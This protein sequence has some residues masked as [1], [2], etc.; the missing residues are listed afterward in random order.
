MLKIL[1][2]I[3]SINP[4]EGGTNLAV[5]EIVKALRHFGVDAEIATT[6]DNGSSN[7]DVPLQELIEYNDVPV[8]FFSR[9]LSNNFKFINEFK[10]SLEFTG[11][12]E[13]NIQNYHTIH[14]HSF[15]SYLCTRG[16]MIARKKKINYVITPHGQLDNWVINQKRWKKEIY[17]LLWERGNLNNATA[18]HCTTANEANDV[19]KFGIPVPIFTIPL[20]VTQL[21]DSPEA[22]RILHDRYQI[23]ITTPIILYLSRLHPKKRADLLL[24]SL[25]QLK[26]EKE[27]YL[28]LAGSGDP[29]YEKYLRNLVVELK[30]DAHTTFT[31]FVQGREK[32][33]LLQGS[34]IFTLPSYG[35]NFAI[36]VAEA[37]AAGL[38]VIITPE[39]QISTQVLAENAGLVVPGEL[40]LWIE[41]IK[42]L[43][44]SVEIRQAIGTKGKNLALRCY[45]WQSTA[46]GLASVYTKIIEK[47]ST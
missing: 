40:N 31:G 1:H 39:V 19:R 5:L 25:S 9:L 28:I 12:L 23:P 11:W 30:L 45:N 18:I 10:M 46:E 13:S 33:L 7:L 43:L 6:N 47:Q 38:P 32:T 42:Q 2:I 44:D 14:I 15:F 36:A 22:K 26:S 20:G 34:D 3:P 4:V 21:T 16:A 35:E 17:S 8:R 24:Q 27:F 41:A 37:M 29:E